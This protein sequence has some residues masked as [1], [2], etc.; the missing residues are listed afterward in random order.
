MMSRGQRAVRQTLVLLLL[1]LRRPFENMWGGI[2][3]WPKQ[4]VWIA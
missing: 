4:R 2:T 1:P 3:S